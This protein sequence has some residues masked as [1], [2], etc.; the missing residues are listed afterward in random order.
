MSAST[1]LRF[2]AFLAAVQGI[3]H[4]VLFLRAK[5]R[6]GAAEVAV[7]D[8]MKSNHFDFAGAARSYWDFY[9]GYGLEAAA[10]CIV[11]AILLT[12]LASIAELQPAVV[13]P[14]VALCIAANLGHAL[15]TAR[16]F[17]YLPIVFD[18]SIAAVLI[19]AFVVAGR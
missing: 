16:Y 14:T 7:I 12:Q 5:P 9:F 11:E 18:V 4:G 3:A 19:W 10:V 15:L 2:S 17:F 6:H 8:A 1:I 13:R